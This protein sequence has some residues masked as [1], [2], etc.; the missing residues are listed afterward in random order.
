MP[1]HQQ[2]PHYLKIS[3][4]SDGYPLPSGPLWMLQP[5]TSVV[6]ANT[7]GADI[8]CTASGSPAP[9]L[10]WVR[11]D[12]SAVDNIPGL[13]TVLPNNTLR[14]HPFHQSSFRAGVH[15]SVYRCLASNAAGTVV[16]NNVTV[17]ADLCGWRFRS[18]LQ[19]YRRVEGIG[20]LGREEGKDGG[21]RGS[22]TAKAC[23]GG[24]E[25]VQVSIIDVRFLNRPEILLYISHGGENKSNH[26][27]P[28]GFKK[29]ASFSINQVAAQPEAQKTTPPG[30]FRQRV[31]QAGKFSAAILPSSKRSGET[32]GC[33]SCLV[34]T[35]V[36]DSINVFSYKLIFLFR[37]E[38]FVQQ[39]EEKY[40]RNNSIIQRQKEWVYLIS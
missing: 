37:A 9:E 27:A 18:V 7:E 31:G 15:K 40:R 38:V 17:R 5:P 21:L 3:A 28:C 13:V 4:S 12:G 19:F 6:F 10:D 25:W 20:R 34:F 11:E 23:E 24:W 35:F 36:S 33:F 8:S 29:S 32:L 14:F 2:G 26:Y 1:P 30:D 22:S 16:S 39:R